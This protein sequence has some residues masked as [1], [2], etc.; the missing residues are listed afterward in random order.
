MRK[1]LLSLFIIL[2]A[3]VSAADG[4]QLT[5]A[6]FE[7]WSGAAFDGQPQPQGWNASNVE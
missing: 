6:N 2:A 4:F 3:L 5:N 1:F 7:D